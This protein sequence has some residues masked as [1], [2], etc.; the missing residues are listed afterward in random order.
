MSSVSLDDI[1]AMS[2]DERIRLVEEVWDS[3]AATPEAVPL[4]AAQRQQ[5]DKR[6]EAYEQN[7]QAGS[8]WEEVKARIVMSGPTC[9]G[10]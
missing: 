6:L 2:V 5:L 4:T 7:P 1:L 8:S 3:I 9:R 10:L